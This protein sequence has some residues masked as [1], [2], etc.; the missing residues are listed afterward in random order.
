VK[1]TREA[2]LE[3]IRGA[4]A[5]YRELGVEGLYLFNFYNAFGSSRPHDDLTYR[6]LRDVA[7]PENLLGQPKVFAVTKSYY[8]DGPGSYAYGKQLPAKAGADGRLRLRLPVAERTE[9]VPFPL[10]S[11]EVRVGW[12]GAP[13]GAVAAVEFN[14]RRLRA[15]GEVAVRAILKTAPRPP[16][17]AEYYAHWVVPDPT[18]MLAGDNLVDVQ[19]AVPGAGATITDVELRYDYENDYFKLWQREPVELNR[20]D[21]DPADGRKPR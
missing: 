9:L 13:G 17:A 7:R 10:K 11:C 6:T 14:E 4:T 20:V 18:V 12:R 15:A 8:N 2:T 3:E 19:L 5:V 16:D 1:L 21:P